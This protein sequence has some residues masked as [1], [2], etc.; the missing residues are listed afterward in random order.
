MR[1]YNVQNLD[2]I[3]ASALHAPAL[4]WPT[5]GGVSLELENHMKDA[6]TA[7]SRSAGGGRGTI[8]PVIVADDLARIYAMIYALQYK[9]VES[10]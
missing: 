4:G 7:N 2:R 10:L 6:T 5:E 9:C 1:H 8:A 3:L